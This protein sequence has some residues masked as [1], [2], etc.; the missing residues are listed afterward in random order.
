MKMK[1]NQILINYL[2]M[3]TIIVLYVI[4]A[5]IPQ[6]LFICDDNNNILVDELINVNNLDDFLFKKF[7]IK[8]K[9]KHNTHPKSNTNYKKYLS[10]ENIKDIREIYKVDYQ[11]LFGNN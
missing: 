2:N 11:I 4:H 6:Y 8:P 9:E 5:Y 10:E 3:I 7:N 1:L